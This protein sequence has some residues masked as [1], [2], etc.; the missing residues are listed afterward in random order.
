LVVTLLADAIVA[1][2]AEAGALKQERAEGAA[3]ASM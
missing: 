2:K 3:A 1:G